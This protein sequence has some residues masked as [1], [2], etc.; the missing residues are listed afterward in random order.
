[1]PARKVSFDVPHSFIDSRSGGGESEIVILISLKSLMPVADSAT[2]SL[3]IAIS[4]QSNTAEWVDYEPGKGY[5]C[6]RR[7]LP[8][9]NLSERRTLQLMRKG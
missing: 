3:A 1:M 4:A 2:N 5:E 9:E 7:I 8:V 6:Y